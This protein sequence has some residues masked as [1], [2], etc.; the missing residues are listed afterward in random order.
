MS[1][2]ARVRV[3]VLA[4][5]REAL[6]I[7]GEMRQLVH[8][9]SV[10]DPGQQLKA[11]ELERYESVRLFVERAKYRD[12]AFVLAEQNVQSVAQICDRLDGIPLAI[13]LAAARVGVPVEQIASRLD[14]SLGL[15]T[16]GAG[17][18]RPGSG[19]SRGLWTGATT[20]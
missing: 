7:A 18:P 3:W 17:A 6:G 4:T 19:R 8:P 20:S 2:S 10:P 16:A 5:S 1:S 11:E 12:P 15:L 14:D 13:E 9:L